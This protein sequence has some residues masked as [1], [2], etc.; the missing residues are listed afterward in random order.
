MLADTPQPFPLSHG[1]STNL[2]YKLNV[3]TLYSQSPYW[4]PGPL[5]Y[6]IHSV[7]SLNETT[8]TKIQLAS[9][10]T[11]LHQIGRSWSLD[12]SFHSRCFCIHSPPS[13][14]KR[15]CKL[16]IW[17]ISIPFGWPHPLFLWNVHRSSTKLYGIIFP[18]G[19]NLVCMLQIRELH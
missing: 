4:C 12:F 3:L 6:R 11:L 9:L 16:F 1:P 13:R 14:E 19:E 2:C 10:K 17:A 7:C 18:K 5:V 15:K 8:T